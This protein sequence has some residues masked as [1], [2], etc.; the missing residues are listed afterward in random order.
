MSGCEQGLSGTVLHHK[1]I[2]VNSMNRRLPAGILTVIVL[3]LA[4]GCGEA[5]QNKYTAK[6]EV[7]STPKTEVEEPGA[8]TPDGA[9]SVE[10]LT[11]VYPSLDPE[12]LRETAA[13]GLWEVNQGTAYGYLTPDGRYLIQGD[14]VDLQTGE[15]LTEQ[16][17]NESRKSVVDQFDA[18]QMISFAPKGETKHDLYIFTDVDCGYCRKLHRELD[19][20]LAKGIAIHYLFYPRSG[21][22]SASFKTAESVWCADDRQAA[23]TRAKA[24]QSVEPKQCDN[25]IMAQYMAGQQVGLRGTPMILLAD[26]TVINGYMPAA[27][28]EERLKAEGL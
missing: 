20:Y 4:A 16:R 13:S 5:G 27:R 18:D 24:N 11:A 3:S 22:G 15:S 10:L 21:P 12:T 2:A 8:A 25:P 7:E 1:S 14:L 6:A 9:P 26:G 17:R 19:D 28:L 23:L